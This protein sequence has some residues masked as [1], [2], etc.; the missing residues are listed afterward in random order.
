M[1]HIRIYYLDIGV[2]TALRPNLNHVTEPS[3]TGSKWALAQISK[4]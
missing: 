4:Y 2:L 1:K 3:K